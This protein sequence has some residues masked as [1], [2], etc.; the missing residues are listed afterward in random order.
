MR[1]VSPSRSCAAL[2]EAQSTAS[3]AGGRRAE[4]RFDP[5]APALARLLDLRREQADAVGHGGERYDALLD[6]FE[7]EMTPRGCSPCW[8]GCAQRSFPRGGA[9]RR[10]PGTRGV[11][12]RPFDRTQQWRFTLELLELLG[13]D[14]K[15]GR[16][17]RSIHP[18]TGGTHPHDV[19]LT[20][21]IDPRNPSPAVFGTMHECGHGLYEQG[22]AAEHHRTPL[23]AAP[24]MGL[25]ES[26]S[27]LWE[28]LVGRSRPFWGFLYPR[29]RAAFPGALGGSGLEEFHAGGQ[30]GRARR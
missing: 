27:R 22:F 10:G 20:T 1:C 21:R 7:P 26:Q 28:N 23:A 13:F 3:R 19:R 17:D 29:L 12:G 16:Q 2:A 14:L 24:S 11:R 30:P 6:H 25:H 5:F 15:A 4:R 9:G 18:F 8:S